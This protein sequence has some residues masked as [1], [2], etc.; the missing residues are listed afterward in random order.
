MTKG[1][2]NGRSTLAVATKQATRRAKAHDGQLEDSGTTAIGTARL[3]KAAKQD[4]RPED[5]H[6]DRT[7]H[8]STQ[9]QSGT[10]KTISAVP[11]VDAAP[12]KARR[13][14]PSKRL[15]PASVD[16]LREATPIVAISEE[17]QVAALEAE[18]QMK[19]RE[20]D[21]STRGYDFGYESG[22]AA[23]TEDTQQL[24]TDLKF[25]EGMT[26]VLAIVVLI[27]LVF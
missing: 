14:R 24:K 21:A 17:K 1:N 6:G 12:Q 26:A 20:Q 27:R 10:K 8:A 16:R 11:G 13:G 3:R 7:D 22:Y 4:P 2:T 15:T 18:A 5:K 9:R 23:G 25:F 19:A